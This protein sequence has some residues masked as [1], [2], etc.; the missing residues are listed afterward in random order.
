MCTY[1]RFLLRFDRKQNSVKQLFSNKLIKKKKRIHLQC[2]RCGADKCLIPGSEDP[3]EKDMAT[4]S[5][6]LLGKSHQIEEPG[7]LWSMGSQRVKHD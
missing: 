2:R 5:S 4:Y 3:L 1:G 7:R 6:I